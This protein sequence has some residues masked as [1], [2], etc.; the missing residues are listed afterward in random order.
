MTGVIDILRARVARGSCAPHNDG[1]NIAL[2]VEGGAMRG[3]VS[4]G[5][6]WALE[7]LGYVDA[8]DA[9]YGSSA[10]AISSAYFLAGQAGLGTT[11]YFEDINNR[12]FIDPSRA[13]IGRPIVDLGY[14]INDVAMFRKRLD[15]DRVLRSPTPLSVL[16][17]DVDTRQTVVFRNFAGATQL[18]GALR[19]GA[20]MP[21]VA[22]A[23]FVHD[24]RRLLD[25]SL[26][27]PIP[28]SSAEAGGH[29][30]IVVLMTR[31]GVMR[32]QPSAFDRYFVGPRLR[33]LSPALAA[34]YLSR[35][36]PYSAIVKAIDS[37]RGLAGTSEVIGVRVEGLRISKLERR[38]DVLVAAARRGY[39]RIEQ[40]FGEPAPSAT[41]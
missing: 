11:I 12:L 3:V 25:A 18:L 19:A 4:A 23:P 7:D 9:V 29:S 35:A 31:S 38:R 36:E 24:A 16:A 39:E 37:G 2:A 33:R 1:A 27:E 28:L 32:E 14:L 15:V 30:H 8:F 13:L 6:V 17:T 22:G 26:S 40:L 21:V 5:M 10:G 20:T 34:Q 41:R